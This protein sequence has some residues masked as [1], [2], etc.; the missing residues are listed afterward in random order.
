[1]L[2]QQPAAGRRPGLLRLDK[3]SKRFGGVQAL[4]DISF[5]VAAGEVLCLAGENGCGKSTL[6]KIISGVHAP[7]PGAVM[8]FDGKPMEHLTPA[9][10]RELGIQVIWQDLALFP[11]MSVAENIAFEQSLGDRPRWVNRARMREV[12][13]AAIRRL[14]FALDLDR[15]VRE[16][17][18]A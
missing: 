16:L 11:E 18:I 14:G 17:S 4:K 12:A 7:E 3:I 2:D 13:G 10:A 9:R 15:P 8:E 6:I 5:D 1:M